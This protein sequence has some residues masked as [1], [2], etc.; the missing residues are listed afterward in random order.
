MKRRHVPYV[1]GVLVSGAIATAAAGASARMDNRRM[2]E[3]TRV[4]TSAVYAV[5]LI[6]WPLCALVVVRAYG[7]TVNAAICL[8]IGW[9]MLLLAADLVGANIRRRDQ[10]DV[11]AS[12]YGTLKTVASAVVGGAWALGALLSVINGR[13]A[14]HTV[15]SAKIVMLSLVV[16]VACV[17][18][19]PC[20]VSRR[21]VAGIAIA[22]G[23]KCAL[24]YAIGLFI[25]GIG[26]AVASDGKR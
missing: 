19:T 14:G 13:D 25:L 11:E 8:G 7:G 4:L 12:R 23:Q 3:R 24:H 17:L 9:T 20:N 18:P 5:A 16:S 10:L 6:M 1:L 22:S 2:K 26:A 21:S 15:A